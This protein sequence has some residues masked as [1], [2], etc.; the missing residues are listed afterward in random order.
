MRAKSL[1]PFFPKALASFERARRLFRWSLRRNLRIE[2][3]ILAHKPAEAPALIRHG[4]SGSA[5]TVTF[6][7]LTALSNRFAN[8]LEQLSVGKSETVAIC[9]PQMPE[10]VV[11]HLG[12]FKRQAISVPLSPLHG[13]D[14]VAKRLAISRS[15]VLAST[16]GTA[17]KIQD[18]LPQRIR[19]R[20]MIVV[21]KAGPGDLLDMKQELKGVSQKPPKPQSTPEAPALLFFTSGTS[22]EPKG[23]LLPHRTLLGRTPGFLLAHHPF[24]QEGDIFWSP[25]DWAWV[26]G[27]LDSLFCPLVY[28][29]PVVT[30]ARKGFEPTDAYRLLKEHRVRCACIP[31]TALRMMGK[32]ADLRWRELTLRSV[33]SGGEP[34]TEDAYRW[35]LHS[36]K[37]SVNEIY[38]LT[39]ASFL[40]GNSSSLMRVKPRSMGKPYPGHEVEII[41]EDGRPVP[42]FQIGEIVVSREDP[43]LFLAYWRDPGATARRFR[44]NWFLTGDLAYRDGEGYFYFVGRKDDLI[45]SAGYLVSPV[46]VE[47]CLLRHPQVEEAA[48]VGVPDTI[49]GTVVKA[50]VVLKD[51]SL[52]SP[53]LA[54][55][56]QRHVRERLGSHQYPRLLEF[57]SSIPKT[58]T[59]KV[60]RRALRARASTGREAR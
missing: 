47:S 36:L 44:N 23:V 42:T 20:H 22:T 31:P 28:G 53:A 5:V 18:H 12:V 6:G 58:I 51:P 25:A 43:V 52:A 56:I 15:K 55:R 19:P 29:V 30:F 9:L 1:R 4:S 38:G 57:V 35:A 2:T 24:P 59:G 16:E 33:H 50:F 49:R 27:L 21:D 10:A 60:M 39:E 8:L 41:G 48:V 34:L 13:V 40:I 45:K 54:T 26:A 32:A 7:T 37:V 14:A 46:E 11:A 3:E 17:R